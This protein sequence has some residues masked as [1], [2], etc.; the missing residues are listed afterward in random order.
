MKTGLTLEQMAAELSRRHEAK[1][2]FVADTRQ[3]SAMQGPQ[4]TMNLSLPNGKT[5]NL[6]EG[7]IFQEQ[8]CGHYKIPRDYATRIRS[9]HP[10][11][12][13]QTLNTHFAEE[14]ARRMVRVLDG[15]ARAF[16]SD[17]YRPLDNFELAEAVLPE[18]LG[19]KNVRVE[20]TQF[21]DRRFYLKAV[22][23]S[24]LTEVKKGD[25]IAMGLVV[26][27]SEVGSGALQVLPFIDR[28]WCLNGAI[29]TTYG[30]KRY[31]VGKRAS[32]EEAAFELYSDATRA[33]DDKVFFNK[34]RDT[35][36]GVLQ[37]GVLEEIA[38]KMRDATEQ[39]IT[40]KD[41][42]AVVELT[43][44]T[45]GYTQETQAGILSHLISGGDFTRYGLMNAVTRQSQDES[46]YERATQ[47]EIDG[48]R[49]IELPKQDW[50]RLAL[51]EAA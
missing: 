30:Q 27:N 25:T 1:R 14:P 6:A 50:S 33:L 39:K 10:E 49:I 46:D 38:G 34:V 32:E 20:S 8:V 43:A 23:H 18:L 42:P 2:D 24:V 22:N 37:R 4:V 26:S 36:R 44:K 7:P 5:A 3:L 48:A 9:A 16:L 11:L 51:A 41:I 21:T 15:T 13:A 17:R 40:S 19:Q 47:L 45:F 12:Y 31:H 29:F 28:L 35:V